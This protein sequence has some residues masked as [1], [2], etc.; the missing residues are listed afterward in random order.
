MKVDPNRHSDNANGEIRP[1]GRPGIRA[2]LLFTA[3][4]GLNVALFVGLGV[5]THSSVQRYQVIGERD[6]L[7]R[8]LIGEIGRLDEVLTMSAKMAVA[9]GDPSWADRYRE[10]EGRLDAAI[11]ELQS[12]SPSVRAVEAAAATEA[13]NLELVR[14][15]RAAFDLVRENRVAEAGELLSG[16]EYERQKSIYASGMEAGLGAVRRDADE[17]LSALRRRMVWAMTGILLAMVTSTA[18]WLAVLRTLRRQSR[19]RLAAQEALK[20]AKDDLEARVIERTAELEAA[21]SRMVDL[22][23]EAGMAEIASGVLHNIG[24]VLNSINVSVSVLS[25]AAK[26][27]KVTGVARVC[28]L[29]EG[30]SD[31]LGA[32]L[33]GDERGRQLLPYLGK[34][35]VHLESER[36]AGVREL[37]LLGRNVDHVKRILSAQQTYARGGSLEVRVRPA[38]LIEDALRIVAL[39]TSGN[40]VEVER[41]FDEVPVILTDRHKVVQI[42]VNLFTN[43]RQALDMGG[44]A[45]R[46]VRIH[47]GKSR[48]GASGIEIEVSDNGIGIAPEHMDRLFTYG[49]T[50]RADGHGFGLHTS[51]LAAGAMGGSLT[52]RSEGSGLGAVFTLRLPSNSEVPA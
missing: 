18:T 14:M 51:A 43:A 5:H 33:T 20:S 26:N 19:A 9:T 24:N 49:F 25:D 7:V 4:L 34:L 35:A 17:T 23:R 2:E 12:L 10:H 32:F 50:T 36:A 1:A 30:H 29:A 42:L 39:E 8:D 21:H 52:A 46:R 11:G 15:E 28:A 37:E 13:A 27:S 44:A 6:G 31:D 47:L 45:E 3:A 16:E 41:A 22:S 48:G 40:L 38:E